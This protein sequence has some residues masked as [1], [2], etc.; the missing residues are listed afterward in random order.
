LF[1]KVEVSRRDADDQGEPRLKVRS[2]IVQSSANPGW[3]GFIR[4]PAEYWLITRT[5]GPGARQQNIITRTKARSIAHSMPCLGK[6]DYA[7]RMRVVALAYN[8]RR[9]F[10][11]QTLLR[12]YRKNELPE[13]RLSLLSTYLGHAHVT[14]TYWYLTGI[15][16]LLGA[17]SKRWEKRWQAVNAGRSC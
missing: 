5:G 1:I 13:R 15:P 14:D 2:W 4:P 12:W 3:C 17:A 11:V 6:S 9:R 16:E 8:F 10:A 7:L